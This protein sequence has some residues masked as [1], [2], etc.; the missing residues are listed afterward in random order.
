MPEY[1]DWKTSPPESKP[2]RICCSCGAELYEG[3]FIYDI[4]GEILCE[5]CIK[6]A[7]GVIL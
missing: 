1:D 5:D 2:L 3:D 4:S 6:D 7:Y